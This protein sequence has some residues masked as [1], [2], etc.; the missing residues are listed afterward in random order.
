MNPAEVVALEVR[1]DKTSFTL[2]S[3]EGKPVAIAE[4]TPLEESPRALRFVHGFELP[5]AA[6]IGRVP[7]PQNRGFHLVV[8]RMN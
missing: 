3:D 6:K 8:A 4:E 1:E 7:D 5:H 2:I